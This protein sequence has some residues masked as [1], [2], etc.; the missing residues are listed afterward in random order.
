[1]D[2]PVT[3]AVQQVLHRKMLFFCRLSNQ[4][5]DHKLQKSPGLTSFCK[6]P[7]AQGEI[8]PL[9]PKCFIA[10]TFALKFTK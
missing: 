5:T 4:Q 10:Q 6:L 3:D 1:M 8:T 7:A 2:Q 9:Q